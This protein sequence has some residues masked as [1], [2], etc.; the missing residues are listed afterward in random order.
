V[1]YLECP[2]LGLAGKKLMITVAVIE[3][4]LQSFKF[5]LKKF[6]HLQQPDFGTL[7]E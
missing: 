2:G 1:E 5:N 3:L 7:S 4:S 6:D